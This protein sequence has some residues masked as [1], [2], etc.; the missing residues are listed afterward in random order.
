MATVVLDQQ[1]AVII[2]DSTWAEKP[3]IRK[4][5]G[6]SDPRAPNEGDESVIIARIADHTNPHGLWIELNQA[7]TRG[8]PRF[9][10]HNIF[11]PWVAIRSILYNP[12]RPETEE[13]ELYRIF[14]R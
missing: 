1:P 14:G 9:P 7:R 4:M 3:W 5:L 10:R 12:D 11:L 6:P 2:V 13:D 8:T